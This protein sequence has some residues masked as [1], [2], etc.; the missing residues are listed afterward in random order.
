[1]LARELT[2]AEEAALGR[3]AHAQRML[4]RIQ[5]EDLQALRRAEEARVALARELHAQR[6]LELGELAVVESLLGRRWWRKTR[7][8]SS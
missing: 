7:L 3:D 5:L 4:T 1:L 2:R 8:L 6:D